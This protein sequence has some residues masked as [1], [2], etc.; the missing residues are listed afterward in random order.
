MFFLYKEWY[1]TIDEQVKL[2][3][4]Y[5]Q[6]R[7]G[8]KDGYGFTDM[9]INKIKRIKDWFIT[10]ED[11]FNVKR[12]RKDFFRFITEHDIRR[13]TNFVKTFPELEEFYLKCKEI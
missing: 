1:H 10:E 11:D 4:F 8:E 12:N 3:D 7:T 13:N 5:E 2:A 9:E 6:V